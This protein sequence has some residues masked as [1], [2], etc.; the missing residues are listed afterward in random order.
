M[1]LIV[2]FEQSGFFDIS[3]GRLVII[4]VDYK[5]IFLSFLDLC[6]GQLF[7]IIKIYF[8]VGFLNVM[9]Y[10]EFMYFIFLMI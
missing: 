1:F 3:I 9:Y 6:L 8:R 10:L 7:Q 5:F 4:F 2:V